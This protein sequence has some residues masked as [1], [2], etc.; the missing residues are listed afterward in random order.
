M[1][2]RR[3]GDEL[4]RPGQ[5]GRG[6]A[7]HD[8][9]TAVLYGDPVQYGVNYDPVLGTSSLDIPLTPTGDSVAWLTHTDGE[10]DFDLD[11]S[12][13]YY[14][15]AL[16]TIYHHTE[17]TGYSSFA[18]SHLQ[19]GFEVSYLTALEEDQPYGSLSISTPSAFIPSNPIVGTIRAK[20]YMDYS[21]LDAFQL[22]VYRLTHDT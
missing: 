13:T 21:R 11:R 1:N 3:R 14:L 17:R 16:A 15:Y 9:W 2:E 8:I 7:R 6:S 22:M 5:G 12:E 18:Y 10:A 20:N 4:V 19:L